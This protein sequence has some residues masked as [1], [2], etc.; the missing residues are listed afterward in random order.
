MQN[1]SF[2]NFDKMIVTKFC[3]PITDLN[4]EKH[5][6]LILGAQNIAKSRQKFGE[7]NYNLVLAVPMNLKFNQ[8]FKNKI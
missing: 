6:V 3:H 1:R 5:S 7:N 2:T 4:Y 8:R